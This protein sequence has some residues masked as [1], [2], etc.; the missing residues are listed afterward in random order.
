MDPNEPFFNNN[1]DYPTIPVPQFEYSDE[2][3]R[4]YKNLPATTLAD[5]LLLKTTNRSHLF[6]Y[7]FPNSRAVE[8]IRNDI[9][10][11]IIEVQKGIGLSVLS[12]KSLNEKNIDTS[13]FHFLISDM[14][15]VL[16]ERNRP[17]F[18]LVVNTIVH[19]KNLIK[20]L[21]PS[22]KGIRALF[23]KKDVETLNVWKD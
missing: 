12:N 5:L 15:Y 2:A 23:N 3:K 10:E 17:F 18:M 22:I 19:D 16:D 9:D 6:N 21:P 4:I 20:D 7:G 1:E 13:K 11:N 8:V 14:R